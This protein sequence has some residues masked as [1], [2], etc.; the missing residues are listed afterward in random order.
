MNLQKKLLSI[1][2]ISIFLLENTLVYAQDSN[3]LWMQKSRTAKILDNF[4]A[5][6]QVLLFD[7]VPISSGE[8]SNLFD[9][10]SKISSLEQIVKRLEDSKE[11]IKEKK[12]NVTGKKISL[13]N[14]IRQIDSDIEDTQ[15]EISDM[16]QEIVTKNQKI[17]DFSKKI[18]E[19]D[20][21]ISE[22]KKSILKYL[23]Y[24]YSKGDLVY[25]DN[26]NIDVI[27]SIILNDWNMSDIINDIHFKS[28]VELSGQ[29]LIETHRD[30]IKEFYYNKEEVKKEKIEN[31]RLKSQLVTKN[32]DLESQKSYK[33]N[34]L[35]VTKWQ[36]ALFNRYI[37][38]KQDKEDDVKTRIDSLSNDYLDVFNN[39][40]NKYNCNFNFSSGSVSDTQEINDSDTPKCKEIKNYFILEKKLRDNNDV[41]MNS[42]NPL[43]WPATPASWIS[44]YFHDED[45]FKEL[46]SEHPAIDIPMPQWTDLAAP[47]ASYVYFVSEPAPG[48]YWY[49]ALKHAWW[50]VTVYGHISEV[51]VKQFDFIQA[52]QVFARSWWAPWTP[53]AWPMTSWSHLHLEV[54]K[55]RV[56]VDPLTFLDTTYLKF[57][58]LPIKYRY[59]YIEDLKLRYGNRVNLDK[60]KKFYIVWDTEIDRQKYLLSKYAT[61]DFNN[62]NIWVEEWMNWKIDPSFLICVW[63]AETWIGKN[64]KTPFNV[65]N[66]W[67]TDSGWTY[68][69]TTPRDWIYWMVKTLDNKY[70]GNYSTIDM[71]S[72]W[73]NKDGAIYASSEKNWHNNVTRCLWSLKWTYIEDNYKFRLN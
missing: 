7:N 16:E 19:L 33:E 22:N 39:I 63:L 34:L 59:K 67:N 13:K 6:Q 21:K 48:K 41:N 38:A 49:I 60:Y 71:L 69:F 15:K 53:W 55:D 11:Q 56:N 72:R 68:E 29:N 27:K 10:D 46:W 31:L 64:L 36:E 30:L 50:F 51:L 42:T 65:W 43:I 32:N 66:V 58:D 35:E 57:E 62:W 52:W 5:Q 24:I 61:P 26:E 1:S 4:N 73:W 17:I 18:Q 70:L 47:A 20:D 40:W 2:I 23:S 45:Y 14:T 54:Y 12:K 37:A 25:W 3:F 28:L 9:S 8:E 44:T